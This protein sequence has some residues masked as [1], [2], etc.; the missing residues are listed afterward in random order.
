MANDTV[1]ARDP[2][3]QFVQLVGG[4]AEL[5]AQPDCDQAATMGGG[6]AVRATRLNSRFLDYNVASSLRMLEWPRA[7]FR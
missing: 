5:G 1:S 4:M 3:E 6:Y 2:G 7:A